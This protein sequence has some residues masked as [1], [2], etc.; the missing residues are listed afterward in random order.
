MDQGFGVPGEEYAESTHFS[1][2]VGVIGGLYV[3]DFDNL[4]YRNAAIPVKI[5]GAGREFRAGSQ[6]GE[7]FELRNYSEATGQTTQQL[8]LTANHLGTLELP[9][10]LEVGF[11]EVWVQTYIGGETPKLLRHHVLRIE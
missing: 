6:A 5:H 9:H 7:T 3:S 1:P 11:N 2:T 4:V 10:D 8:S